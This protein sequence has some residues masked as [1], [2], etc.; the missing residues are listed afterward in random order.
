MTCIDKRQYIIYSLRIMTRLM[1]VVVYE[2]REICHELAVR[3]EKVDDYRRQSIARLIK[4]HLP[5]IT[6][7]GGQYF[8]SERELEELA[9]KVQSQKRPKKY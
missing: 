8:L 7:T 5:G 4:R 2:M 9:S 3:T 1:T 6:K